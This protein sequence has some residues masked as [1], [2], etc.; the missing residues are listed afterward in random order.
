M[1]KCIEDDTYGREFELRNLMMDM[2]GR[3]R[4]H[5]ICP[6]YGSAAQVRVGRHA[7]V[8]PD[9]LQWRSNTCKLEM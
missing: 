8:H 7:Y 9:V 5:C 6:E 4:V 3:F 1:R 2:V